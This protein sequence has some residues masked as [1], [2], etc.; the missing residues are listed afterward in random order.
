MNENKIRKKVQIVMAS[1]NGSATKVS[2]VPKI[3]AEPLSAKMYGIV[4]IK[5]LIVVEVKKFRMLFLLKKFDFRFRHFSTF[6][7]AINSAIQAKNER[8]SEALYM[9]ESGLTNV[10]T[11]SASTSDCSEVMF[12]PKTSVK[13]FE[14][15]MTPARTEGAVSP[16][17]NI[18]TQEKTSP[19]KTLNFLF[20]FNLLKK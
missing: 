17:K 6:G 15:L 4:K 20:K 8:W 12:L 1:I 7:V 10:R 18:N 14:L 13:I 3:F 5:I 9:S 16:V 11:K 19:P 2:N